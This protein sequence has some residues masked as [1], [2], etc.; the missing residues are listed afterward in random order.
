[1]DFIISPVAIG[2]E[3]PKIADRLTEKARMNPV[4]E[5]KMDYYTALP[6][7]TGTPAV[8]IPIKDNEKNQFPGSIK[9]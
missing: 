1:M 4:Y 7:I 5:Y 3:P 8:T 2:E 6:N 9:V